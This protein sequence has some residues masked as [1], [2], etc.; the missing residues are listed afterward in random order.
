MQSWKTPKHSHICIIP[1]SSHVIRADGIGT[2]WQT[3]WEQVT[4]G[5]NDSDAVCFKECL[6]RS[7]S[8]IGF[9]WFC[10]KLLS[11][12]LQMNLICWPANEAVLR[13]IS[14]RLKPG[15]KMPSI[16]EAVLFW[17]TEMWGLFVFSL[18]GLTCDWPQEVAVLTF[19]LCTCGWCYSRL[20][21]LSM[22]KKSWMFVQNSV[23]TFC[24]HLPLVKTNFFS[25]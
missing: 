21:V 23:S 9:V 1:W 14:L 7:E 22:H 16:T 15:E 18:R 4:Q 25:F 20:W 10:R 17:G 2:D 11:V 13:H 8:V 19:V 3:L 12:W 24:S 5:Q 6:L